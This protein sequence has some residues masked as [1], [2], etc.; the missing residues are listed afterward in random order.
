MTCLAEGPYEVVYRS[1]PLFIE[2]IYCE[3][4]LKMKLGRLCMHPIDEP[5]NGMMFIASGHFCVYV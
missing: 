5:L 3:Y 4:S 1:L 2:N